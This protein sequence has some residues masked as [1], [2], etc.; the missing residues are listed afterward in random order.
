MPLDVSYPRTIA[1]NGRHEI[2]IKRSRFVCTLAR[3]A[4]EAEARTALDR[5]RQ[6][7]VGADH[8]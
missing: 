5:S 6:E 3:V 1:R 7:L 8:H 2:E 4:S